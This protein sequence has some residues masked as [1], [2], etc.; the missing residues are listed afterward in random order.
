M[1]R[2]ACAKAKQLFV[3]E[4]VSLAP[5]AQRMIPVRFASVESAVG[6]FASSVAKNF[7]DHNQLHFSEAIIT[8]KNPVVPVVN[9]SSRGYTLKKDSKIALAR[10]LIYE[11]IPFMETDLSGNVEINA[12]SSSFS[13]T[14]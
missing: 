3:V 7:K 4:D 11:S 10:E 1:F 8:A 9:F 6:I 5:G 14:R 2:V 13:E 12:T